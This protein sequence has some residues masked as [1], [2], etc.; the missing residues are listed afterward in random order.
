MKYKKII[1]IFVTS[2]TIWGF[3]F[4]V[5]RAIAREGESILLKSYSRLAIKSL[6]NILER[7]ILKGKIAS[8]DK[9]RLHILYSKIKNGKTLL[10][11]CL[12]TKGCNPYTF[13]EIAKKSQLHREIIYKYPYL[14]LSQVNQKIGLINEYLM[15]K[16]FTSG[17]WRKIEGEV[18]R[19]GIDGLF[20]KRKNGK[21]VDVLLV[22][23]KYNKSPLGATKYGKQMSKEWSLKKLD[24]LIKKYPNNKEYLTIK[25]F[26]NKDR[27]R[28]LLWQT[29]LQD[30]KIFL[31]LKKLN[32]REGKVVKSNL[33]GGEKTRANYKGNQKIDINNPQNRFQENM[34][35]WFEEV[36]E[37][38]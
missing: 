36:L 38:I 19:N 6:D 12:N 33:A 29:K 8:I 35:K 16:F 27:H 25:D 28:S 37:K 9:Y 17:G 2:S 1:L 11:R 3:N 15:N 34:V 21:V 20:I 4:G 18:G 24:D 30:N 13:A 14:N 22:E 32:D 5:G 10:N 31:S 26:I 23:S 7:A